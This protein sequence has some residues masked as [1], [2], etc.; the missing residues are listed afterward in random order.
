MR[1]QRSH[2]VYE[3][4]ML[5]AVLWVLVP[6]QLCPERE[7]DREREREREREIAS[8]HAGSLFV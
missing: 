8:V 5:S 6:M 2:G 3:E 4:L 1:Q 7:R